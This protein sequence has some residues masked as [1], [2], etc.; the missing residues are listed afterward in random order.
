MNNVSVITMFFLSGLNETVN[1]RFVL[2]FLSLLCY[3]IIFLLNLALTVTI[4]LDKNL[5]EPMYILLCVFCMNALYGTAGFY[6]KFLWDLLSPVHVISYYGCLIQTHVV[7]SFA[8][9]D[10]SI[11]TL[12]AFDRY[13]AICQPLKY[14]SFMSKQRVI[15]VACFSWFTPFCIVA[16]NI[17]LTSRLKLCS[18]YISRLFCVNSVIVTLACSRAE[19]IINHIA[20]YITITVYVFHGLFIVWSYVYLIKTCVKSTEKR[21]KF[22]QTCVP[23]LVSLLTFLVAILF[24]VLNIRFG[25]I[26]LPQTLQNFVTIEFLVI[27]PIMN[28]LIYGFKLTKIKKR[29]CT[30]ITFRISVTPA[31]AGKELL[32]FRS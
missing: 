12:M 6:P 28:P 4:I 8:C 30:F 2:F 22:M 5:H 21:A 1:H 31:Y 9:I 29:I 20:S 3:C 19:T 26:V 32:S 16:V 13:V 10:V 24:D 27:P 7:Y 25:S 18:S 11:L 23:H 17:F 14:H 15:K